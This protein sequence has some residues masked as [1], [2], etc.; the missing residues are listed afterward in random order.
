METVAVIAI[1]MSM[2]MGASFILEF[3]PSFGFL[4]NAVY[5]IGKNYITSS[6]A[7]IKRM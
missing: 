7:T 3:S 1:G 2:K 5:I 6:I 4:K